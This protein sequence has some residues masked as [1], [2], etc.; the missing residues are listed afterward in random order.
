MDI[1]TA[2]QKVIQRSAFFFLPIRI[3]YYVSDWVENTPDSY[4][5]FYGEKKLHQLSNEEI[6]EL[7]RLIHVHE[8][9]LINKLI[10]NEKQT[11]N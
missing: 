1:N 11:T 5:R 9:L 7:L 10:E 6:K 3:K 8:T 2:N 4:S